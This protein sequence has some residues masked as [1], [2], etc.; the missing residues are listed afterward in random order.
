MK[1][2]L[3]ILSVFI[4]SVI[5]SSAFAKDINLYEKPDTQAKVIATISSDSQIIP[6]IYADKKDWVKIANPKNGDVGWAKVNELKGPMVITTIKDNMIQQQIISAKGQGNNGSEMISVMQ[7]SGSKEMQPKEVKASL[8][9]MQKRDQ[10]MHQQ[11]QRIRE[12]MQK[13]MEEMFRD[14][15]REFYAKPLNKK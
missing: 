7:Y 15:D 6:I 12:E 3:F 5:F 10:E 13:N 11:M 14:F 1:K 2:L 9:R 4:L 8:E